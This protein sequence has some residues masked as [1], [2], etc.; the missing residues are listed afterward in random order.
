MNRF[1]VTSLFVLI[2]VVFSGTSFVPT[3]ESVNTIFETP[4]QTISFGSAVIDIAIA[5]SQRTRRQGLS[6]LPALPPEHGL[7]F[8]FIDSDT[9]GI[10]MKD[11]EFP[12]DIIWLDEHLRVVDIH[13]SVSPD[14]YPTSFHPQVPARFALEV[15][16]GFSVKYDVKV[17]SKCIFK[18]S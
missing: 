15:E 7:F 2:L 14:T 1:F 9:H 11:M 16:A 10:W 13:Q 3:R 8:V 12:I 4:L 5:D 17:G 6:H 18:T